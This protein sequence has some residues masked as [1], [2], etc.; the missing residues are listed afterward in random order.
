[1]ETQQAPCSS[2]PF[3]HA[4][5]DIR[6]C[7]EVLF[8]VLDDEAVLLDLNSGQYFGLNEIG[9]RIWQLIPEHSRLGAIRDRLVEEYDVTA[10]RAWDDLEI[11]I[12]E[13]IRRGLVTAVSE[14][15]L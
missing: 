10:D 5:T 4:E 1:M 13:L 8:K 3:L 14:P 2:L 7:K 15:H 11:L 6:L 9:C 12:T